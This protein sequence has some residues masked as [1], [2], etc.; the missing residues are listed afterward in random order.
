MNNLFPLYE[1]DT[2]AQ[3]LIQTFDWRD[4]YAMIFLPVCLSALCVAQRPGA[5]YTKNVLGLHMK[6]FPPLSPKN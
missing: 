1:L 5:Y 2:K 6:L 3:F 4:S